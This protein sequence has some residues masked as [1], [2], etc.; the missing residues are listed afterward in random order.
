VTPTLPASESLREPV[1]ATTTQS[2][3]HGHS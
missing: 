2:D 3:N 1:P